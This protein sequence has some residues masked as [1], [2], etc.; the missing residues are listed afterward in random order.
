MGRR[1]AGC[2][3][4]AHTHTHTHTRVRADTHTGTSSL[5]SIISQDTGKAPETGKASVNRHEAQDRILQE[6]E[7]RR[8]WRKESW[9]DHGRQLSLALAAGR[10][11]CGSWGWRSPETS[12]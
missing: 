2:Y 4:R 9:K 1:I 8:S 6:Q 10:I 12:R 5:P 3:T 7:R 11:P